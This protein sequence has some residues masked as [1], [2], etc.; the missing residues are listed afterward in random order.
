MRRWCFLRR[1]I[2]WGSRGE[3]ALCGGLPFY[4]FYDDMAT[5][6]KS[7]RGSSL[8]FWD[9]EQRLSVSFA[10]AMDPLVWTSLFE[11]ERRNDTI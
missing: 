3:V 6:L 4:N 7:L 11:D 2:S 1:M 9:G 10:G 8:P 5:W